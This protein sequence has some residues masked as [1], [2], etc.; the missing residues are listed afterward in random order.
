MD[1]INGGRRVRREIDWIRDAALKFLRHKIGEWQQVA[2]TI[3]DRL[4]AAGGCFDNI[5]ESS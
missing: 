4:P 1:P 2:N 3:D 5:G